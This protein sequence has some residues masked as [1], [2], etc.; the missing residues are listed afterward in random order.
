MKQKITLLAL[1]LLVLSRAVAIEM[2]PVGTPLSSDTLF[3]LC[4]GKS[5]VIQNKSIFA[6]LCQG[7]SHDLLQP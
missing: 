4:A 7:T 3:S 6:S 5:D 1:I 2:H